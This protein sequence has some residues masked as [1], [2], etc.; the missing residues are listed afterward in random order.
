MSS[1]RCSNCGQVPEQTTLDSEQSCELKSAVAPGTRFHSLYNSNEAPEPSETPLVLSISSKIEIQLAALDTEI[2]RLRERLSHLEADRAFLA[3]FRGAKERVL[4]P[5]R[6]LPSEI[7]EEIFMWSLP[8]L[9]DAMYYQDRTIKLSPWV[10]THVCSSWRAVAIS[11]SAL[12]SLL[13]LHYDERRYAPHAIEVQV[14]RARKL[15]IHFYASLERDTDSQIQMLR[16]LIEHSARWEEACLGVTA[17]LAPL[18]LSLRDRIPALR[19]IWL[20]VDRRRWRRS[21]TGG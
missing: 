5:I 1:S 10:L 17:D 3:P 8:I 2:S 18:L 21:R 9:K 20:D 12:W 4:A 13:I 6:R 7:L 19:K 16:Y 14:Q 15:K 11:A